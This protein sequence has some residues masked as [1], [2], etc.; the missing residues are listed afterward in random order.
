MLLVVVAGSGTLTVDSAEHELRLG[1]LAIVEK[2]RARRLHAGPDGIRYVSVHLRRPGLSIGRVSADAAP[3]APR[4]DPT[5][6]A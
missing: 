4:R 5:S 3:G 6:S 1:Q 2:G